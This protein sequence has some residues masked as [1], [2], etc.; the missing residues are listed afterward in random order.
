VLSCSALPSYYCSTL[1][2]LLPLLMSAV[3]VIAAVVGVIAAAAERLEEEDLVGLAVEEYRQACSLFLEQ[4]LQR[5]KDVPWDELV[6]RVGDCEGQWI[7]VVAVAVVAEEEEGVEEF[8]GLWEETFVCDR[9]A[10]Q[11]DLFE[12]FRREDAS[13]VEKTEVSHE[14]TSFGFV[15]QS[16][17]FLPG[18]GLAP[19]GK[20]DE[21][22]KPFLLF[23]FLTHNTSAVKRKRII[24]GRWPEKLS[25]ALQIPSNQ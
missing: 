22:Y 15:A 2:L 9:Y 11:A 18:A 21:L 17:A 14:Q 20:P 10:E 19:I 1:F 23:F 4:G 24:Y 3:W 16:S 8:Q 25:S 7:E 5:G 12:E 6:I 13:E